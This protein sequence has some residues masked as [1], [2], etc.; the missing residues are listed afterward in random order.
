MELVKELSLD[1]CIGMPF[2]TKS[3]S[4]VDLAGVNSIQRIGFFRCSCGGST[5][6][7]SRLLAGCC[8]D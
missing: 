1:A 6:Y 5:L 8:S 3:Y 7:V 4:A 2:E